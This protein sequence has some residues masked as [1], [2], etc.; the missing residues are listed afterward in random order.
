VGAVPVGEGWCGVKRGGPIQRRTPLLGGSVLRRVRIRR[1]RVGVDPVWTAVRRV[2]WTRSD[3]RCE[4]CGQPLDPALWEGHH[5]KFRS[6]GGRHS[7]V[8]AVALD[9]GCHAEVHRG[10]S[11]TATAD[12][13]AVASTRDPATVPVRLYSG[14]LVLL[15]AD[16]EYTPAR[17]EEV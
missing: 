6:R 8:N 11:A 17:P 2:L 7:V 4:R 1:R 15:T 14:Q 12:G 9:A 16:G 13:Y 10:D 5:R 3:G